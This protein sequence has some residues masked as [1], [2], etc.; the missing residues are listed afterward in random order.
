L[1]DIWEIDKVGLSWATSGYQGAISSGQT[2]CGLLI[3]ATVAIG[4]RHG[5]GQTSIPFEAEEERGKAVKA[6]N[7][8]YQEFLTKFNGTN[9][10][11][12]TTIDFSKPEDQARYMEKEIFKDTCFKYF[13]FLMK[14]F[15]DEAKQQDT[16]EKTA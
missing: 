16:D 5:Q 7:A 8:L 12:L 11:T 10:Q 3:G 15:M 1:L 4:L 13:Q 14:R 2:T 9:C 6:V